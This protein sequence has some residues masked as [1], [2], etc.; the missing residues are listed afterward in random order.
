MTF[1]A[2]APAPGQYTLEGTYIVDFTTDEDGGCKS[3]EEVIRTAWS[4]VPGLLQAGLTAM[5][6]LKQPMG[7][8]KSE[9]RRKADTFFELFGRE[10][11]AKG[12]TTTGKEKDEPNYFPTQ[13]W[14][15]FI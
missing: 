5:E 10:I 4:E 7:E 8:D 1:G 2:P 11:P 12:W 15:M 6:D 9:W 13:V 3:Y 14:G